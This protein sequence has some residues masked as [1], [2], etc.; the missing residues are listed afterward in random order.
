MR[1]QVQQQLEIERGISALD[2]RD[3]V[4]AAEHRTANKTLTGRQ[5]AARREAASV[6]KV[7]RDPLR[8][9]RGV[10]IARYCVEIDCT[11]LT[12]SKGWFC[13]SCEAR[14]PSRARK[15]WNPMAKVKREKWEGESRYWKARMTEKLRDGGDGERGGL[16]WLTAEELRSAVNRVSRYQHHSPV[17]N[18]KSTFTNFNLNIVTRPSTTVRTSNIV[19]FSKI[20]I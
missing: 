18:I 19:T 13:P 2:K 20:S 16:G 17:I 9:S 8:N 6:G 7:H 1:N 4:K 5:K 3:K 10:V 15:Y 14:L 12:E 11:Q